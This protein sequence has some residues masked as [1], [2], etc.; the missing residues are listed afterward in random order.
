MPLSTAELIHEIIS[1]IRN[2]KSAHAI[3]H[4]LRYLV[5]IA[6]EERLHTNEEKTLAAATEIVGFVAELVRPWTEF[7]GHETNIAAIIRKH[8]MS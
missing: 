6:I 4:K 3:E 2:M 5:L 1:D 7:R 8:I